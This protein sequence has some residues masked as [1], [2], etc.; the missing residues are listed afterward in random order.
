MAAEWRLEKKGEKM[1]AARV[2][3]RVY[4]TL[5][6]LAEEVQAGGWE[7]DSPLQALDELRERLMKA[8]PFDP[9]ES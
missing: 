2:C 8:L 9:E 7:Y 1:G 4:E 5:D 6:D 3:S